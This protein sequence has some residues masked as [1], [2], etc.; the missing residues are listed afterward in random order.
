MYY[1]VTEY[2]LPV[3]AVN[4]NR[5]LIT[6]GNS[7]AFTDMYDYHPLDMKQKVRIIPIDRLKDF[8]KNGFATKEEAE[9]D[10]ELKKAIKDFV[11]FFF[12]GNFVA[13]SEEELLQKYKTLK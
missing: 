12:N 6:I 1:L 13:M 7:E 3:F 5:K 2:E 10:I 11:G 4:E 9:N 8:M